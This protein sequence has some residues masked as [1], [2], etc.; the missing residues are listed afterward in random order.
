MLRRRSFL[1]AASLLS[2]GHWRNVAWAQVE[3]QHTLH[4]LLANQVRFLESRVSMGRVAVTT[5][6]PIRNFKT[7]ARLGDKHERLSIDFAGTKI[8]LDYAL[9]TPDC[10][11]SIRVVDSHE[12]IVHRNPFPGSKQL[13]LMFVQPVEGRLQLLI[14]SGP[15]QREIQAGTLW[16]LILA[17]R[18]L[19]RRELIPLLELLRPTWQL[20]NTVIDI[21][22][23]LSQWGIP[24][25]SVTP[26]KVRELIDTLGSDAFA[27]R[28]AAERRLA[29]IGPSVMPW[30]RRRDPLKLDAEQRDRIRK[31]ADV[32]GDAEAE[33]SAKG[34]ALWL[35]N[36]P[37]T[38]VLLLQRDDIK[39]R[40]VAV[41]R[42]EKLLGR[43]IAFDIDADESTRTAQ[44]KAIEQQLQ[45]EL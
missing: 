33:D 8:S 17:D 45:S 16:H 1:A 22:A 38:L 31:I 34:A 35:A 19:C 26:A 39:L 3:F 40:R 36:D 13:P 11:Y 24:V 42:L 27:E 18:E 10:Q 28:E 23:K 29:A 32:L 12:V 7:E 9:T 37:E 4:P 20:T 6:D 5:N 30:L 43:P 41:E 21:E 25:L 14:G 44:A 2:L 15:Q